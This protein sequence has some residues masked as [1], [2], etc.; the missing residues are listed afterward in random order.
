MIIIGVSH[1]F[2]NHLY[3]ELFCAHISENNCNLLLI[4]L[5]SLCRDA[6][7]YPLDSFDSLDLLLRP[8]ERNEPI[9]T[10]QTIDNNRL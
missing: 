9:E 10:I 4:K 1:K 5:R 3:T 8:N 2:T 6:T 7:R